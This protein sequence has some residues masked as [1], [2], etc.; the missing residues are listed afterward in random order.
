MEGSSGEGPENQKYKQRAKATQGTTYS[1]KG[2]ISK[3]LGHFEPTSVCHVA[4]PYW[5]S[6]I[7]GYLD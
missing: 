6:T 3:I 4:A 7:F 1:V 5:S 2:E